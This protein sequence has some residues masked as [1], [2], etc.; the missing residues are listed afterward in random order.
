[1]G[2]PPNA[3]RAQRAAACAR[4]ASAL[5]AFLL[6]AARASAQDGT[7]CMEHDGG[8]DCWRRPPA[9]AALLCYRWCRPLRA[10]AGRRAARGTKRAAGA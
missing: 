6:H 5:V 2:K 4:A 1:M 10:S 7:P 8:M 9:R 3:A